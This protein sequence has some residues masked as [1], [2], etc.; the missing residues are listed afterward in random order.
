VLPGYWLVPC[1]AAVAERGKTRVQLA[2]ARL[3]ARA[4]QMATTLS[5]L[6]WAEFCSQRPANSNPTYYRAFR[7]TGQVQAGAWA[8][9]RKSMELRPPCDREH[10]L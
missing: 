6:M 2:D 7:S 5:S 8:R 9:P 3:T 10:A 1:K 4:R